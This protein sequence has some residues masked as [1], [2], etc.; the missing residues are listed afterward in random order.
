M[1]RLR[2][3]NGNMIRAAV[4]WYGNVN[5]SSRKQMSDKNLTEMFVSL[6]LSFI[7]LFMLWR[8]EA[9]HLNKFQWLSGEK[10][11]V[12]PPSDWIQMTVLSAAFCQSLSVT[13]ATAERSRSHTV[14][15]SPDGWEKKWLVSSCKQEDWWCR[16]GGSVSRERISET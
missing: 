1:L 3:L 10:E 12:Y 11:F 14:L 6:P 15:I 5:G 16:K 7:T 4:M 2:S 9:L 8:V 13:G